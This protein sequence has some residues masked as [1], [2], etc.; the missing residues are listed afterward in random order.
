MWRRCKLW[1]VCAY[2]GAVSLIIPGWTRNFQFFVCVWHFTLN[3]YGCDFQNKPHW[4]VFFKSKSRWN[5]IKS[6]SVHTQSNHFR[7][8][9]TWKHGTSIK[10]GIFLLEVIIHVTML[11]ET[12]ALHFLFT[13]AL[14]MLDYVLNTLINVHCTICCCFVEMGIVY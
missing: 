8:F 7:S 13:A 9:L 5:R 11:R 4:L 2:F 10:L 6:Y 3:S 12:I 1:I 14:I